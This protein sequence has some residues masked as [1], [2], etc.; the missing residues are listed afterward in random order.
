MKV[1]ILEQRLSSDGFV[2][3]FGDR[4][5]VPDEVGKIW[6]KHGWAKD[7]SGE[8]ATGERKVINAK[9]DI[10]NISQSAKSEVK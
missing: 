3:E 10:E 6:C 8:V 1:E 7:L 9:L 5:T 4:F 2:G